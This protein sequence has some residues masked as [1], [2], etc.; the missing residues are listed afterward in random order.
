MPTSISQFNDIFE[1]NKPLPQWFVRGKTIL[2]PRNND[3]ELP[4][5]YRPIACLN[6]TYK[7]YTSMLN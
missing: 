7:I 2:L 4:K 3:R 6:K 1:N 5:N